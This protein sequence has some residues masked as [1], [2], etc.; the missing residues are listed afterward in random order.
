MELMDVDA[1]NESSEGTPRIN[2]NGIHLTPVLPETFGEGLPYAPINWPNPGD[3]WSWRV[4]KR[5]ATSGH[6]LDRYL[7]APKHLRHLDSSTSK[8]GGFASKL[9]VERYIRTSFPDA[10]V[11]AF[12]ASFSWKI[13]SK[14][15]SVNGNVEGR[16]FFPALLEDI[17]EDS[18]SDSQSEGV[19]CKAGNKKC[20]SSV[21]DAEYS[22][23]IG[24]PCDICCVEPRFCRDCCCILCN[25]FINLNYGGYSYIRCEAKVG[26]GYICGHVAHLNCALRCYMAGTVGGIIGLDAEYCCRR[27]DAKTDLILHVTRLIQT[28]E[29]VDCRDD[30]QKILNVGV[31]ILRG[32]QKTSAKELLSRIELAIKKLKHGTSLGDIWKVDDSD[33]AI[34]TDVSHFEN[35][36][37]EVITLQ[38]SPDAKT[39]SQPF[40]STY[41]D[42][43]S[44]S[45]NLEEEIDKVLRA[46][47]NSQEYE[48]RIAEGRLYAQKNKLCHLYQQLDK[49]RAEL[50]QLSSEVEPDARSET[51]TS[52]V[53]QIKREVMKLKDMAEVAIGFGRTSKAILKEHFD[54]DVED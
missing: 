42:Y 37:L 21:L 13:P 32:S 35:A 4:G 18:G 54:L 30:V 10:D 41:S 47:R 51:I 26:E 2:G 46:L 15:A 17:R 34:S 5:V 36:A 50:A 8:K 53:D 6:F 24:M 23:L 44:E 16:T 1:T 43:K 29:S 33:V 28:C 3:N 45:Q 31:C 20:S 48:Y 11:K 12:F 27:C 39:S 22:S 49:E 9:S 19:V 14:L 7:Y 38:D 52:R 25:K 40:L